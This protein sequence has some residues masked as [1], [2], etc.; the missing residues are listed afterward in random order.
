M[1]KDKKQA[2]LSQEEIRAF[3]EFMQKLGSTMTMIARAC[4]RLAE[5]WHWMSEQHREILKDAEPPYSEARR[6]KTRIE[7]LR[8]KKLRDFISD[9]NGEKTNTTLEDFGFKP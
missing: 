9:N 2:G 1:S 6:R 5:C 7:I 8:I 4:E 3:L